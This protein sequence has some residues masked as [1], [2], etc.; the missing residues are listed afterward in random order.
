MRFAAVALLATV[1]CAAPCVF[2]RGSS[3]SHTTAS[4]LPSASSPSRSV[5]GVARDAHGKIARSPQALQQFKKANPCPGTGKTYGAYPGYVVDHV[6]PLKRGAQTGRAICNGRRRPRQGRRIVGNEATRAQFVAGERLLRHSVV[7]PFIE[8]D[9]VGG[10]E[11][12]RSS[13][14]CLSHWWRQ[15]SSRSWALSCGSYSASSR[16]VDSK[17]FCSRYEERKVAMKPS[18]SASLLD[19]SPLCLSLACTDL[20]HGLRPA[21]TRDYQRHVLSYGT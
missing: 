2:A 19:P 9:L 20:S 16:A 5:P 21:D 17:Y 10:P 18:R 12:V 3:G 1:V 4:A 6:I 15:V 7:C 14:R 13:R 8:L 11:R